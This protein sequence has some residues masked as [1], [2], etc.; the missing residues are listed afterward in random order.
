MNVLL[1]DKTI[2]LEDRVSLEILFQK[3][4]IK[5]DAGMAVAVNEMIIPKK[6]WPSHDLNENDKILLITAT[7][8][9]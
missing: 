5:I 2:D 3:L 8:G 1:N 7:Q 4:N 9:G 6:E